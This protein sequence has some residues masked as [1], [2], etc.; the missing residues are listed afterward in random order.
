[1]SDDS[2][3]ADDLSSAM[4]DTSTPSDGA[5]AA[6]TVDAP[7][8]EGQA[9]TVPAG[10]A[11]DH[12][13]TE[14]GRTGPIPFDVHK[15]ALENARTKAVAEWEQQYGWAKQVDRQAVA[16]AVRLSQMFANDRA[17]F[18]RELMGDNPPPE[19]ISEFARQLSGRRGAQAEPQEPQPDLPIQLEDGR[20][21]HLYSADQQ[22]K[23][24]AWL[25][26]RWMGQVQEQMA[27]ALS[28]AQEL[29]QAKQ[30][31]ARQQEAQSFAQTFGGQLAQKPHFEELKS[32][33]AERL[34][35]V[36]LQSDHPA[37]VR[38]AAFQIYADLLSERKVAAARRAVVQDIHATARASTVNPAHTST[39]APKS[40][41]EMTTAEYMRHLMA[42]G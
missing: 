8:M 19:L 28:A 3:F 40:V 35:R 16:D 15:T 21:V 34:A 24:E 22:A 12:S 14:P 26:Q 36:Q 2:S 11:A 29:Q 39:A 25:Q 9:T 37:E 1:M 32:A 20:V 31:V 7:A 30:Q 17:G 33:I 4:G 6:A 10:A 27:P 23:R 13:T 41:D 42:Q 18:V 5:G 38:A